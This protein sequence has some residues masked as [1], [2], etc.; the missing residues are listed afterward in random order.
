MKWAERCFMSLR[1]SS[2]PLQVEVVDNGSTDG[3]ADFILENFPEVNLTQSSVNLG[4]GKANNIGIENAYLKGADFFYLMNQDA[5]IYEDSVK[6]MLEAYQE[7]PEKEKIGI[8]SPIHLDGSE[9]KLDIFFE[10]YLS[11]NSHNNR[12]L[13]DALLNCTKKIYEIDFVNAAHW[14]LTKK[15]IEEIGGFNTYF[16]HYSEDYE[17]VQRIM[18]FRKKILICTRSFVVHDGKQTFG[19]TNQINA[20]RVQRE[21]RYLDPGIHFEKSLVYREFLK[22]ILLLFLKGKFSRANAELKEFLYQ[23][24]RIHEIL[25]ARETISKKQHAFLNI[26]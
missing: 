9:K 24:K 6:E 22:D 10:R 25:S 2:V 5:W 21:Q 18:Y 7:Y 19:K 15:T 4:F 20:R 16:F 14:M 23:K 12:F 1:R 26:K 13:S 8:L 3:T 17:Y 11:R